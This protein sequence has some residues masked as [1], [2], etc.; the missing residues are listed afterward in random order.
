MIRVNR[1]QT[2]IIFG[3]LTMGLLATACSPSAEKLNKDGNEAYAEEAYLEALAAYEAALIESPELAEPYYNAANT[4]YREGA[5]SEATM[6]MQEALKYADA[7]SLE[8]SSFYNTGNSS[9]NLQEWEAAIAAYTEAL[10]RNPDDQDAKYN[11]E[12]ALQQLQ[13]QQQEQ[14]QE[15]NE[16]QQEEQSQDGESQEDEQQDQSQSGQDQQDQDQ[17]D[18]DQQQD[19]QSSEG[20]ENQEQDND[21]G[22]PQDEEGSDEQE[23]PSQMPQPGQRMTA[24]QARQ[25]LAAIAQDTET[26]QERLGQIFIAPP[27]PPAQDW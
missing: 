17:V 11:L 13:Q 16:E 19:D 26:L 14:Q 27:I 9:F 1:I 2:V 21:D 8:Q 7:D 4:L 10:L 23:S 3:L 24:E 12:L 20:D 22:Q 18:Q 5:F 15:E 6:L 25:L